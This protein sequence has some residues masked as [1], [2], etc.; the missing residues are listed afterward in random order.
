VTGHADKTHHG[1]SISARRSPS[2]CT[3]L[4]RWQPRLRH[5]R[6]R[7]H[8]T[9]HDRSKARRHQKEK[10]RPLCRIRPE[11]KTKTVRKLCDAAA[12]DAVL[13]VRAVRIFNNLRVMNGERAFDSHPLRQNSTVTIPD[14]RKR[15]AWDIFFS[16]EMRVGRARGSG[17]H[18]KSHLLYCR[19]GN[20]IVY[21]QSVRCI[22]E[23]INAVL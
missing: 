14:Y 18:T 4:P 6:F 3:G 22:I 23:T 1:N 9:N 10:A 12:A 8:G 11:R 17:S 19:A 21:A 13:A 5:L 2:W 7:V 20:R 15:L 16:R